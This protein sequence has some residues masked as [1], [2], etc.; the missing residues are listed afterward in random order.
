M[1]LPSLVRTEVE[2]ALQL[3]SRQIFHGALIECE[4]MLELLLGTVR[5]Y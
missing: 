4:G 1:N 2:A 3:P 5:F